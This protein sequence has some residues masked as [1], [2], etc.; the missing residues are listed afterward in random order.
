MK[1]RKRERKGIY[2]ERKN[3]LKARG[4]DKRGRGGRAIEGARDQE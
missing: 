3:K 4:V 1:E 2:R